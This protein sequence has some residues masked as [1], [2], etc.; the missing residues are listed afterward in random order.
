LFAGLQFEFSEHFA[1]SWRQ[2]SGRPNLD[3]DVKVAFA[4]RVETRHAFAAQ[5]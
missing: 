4:A 3:D 1:L 5:P 2:I